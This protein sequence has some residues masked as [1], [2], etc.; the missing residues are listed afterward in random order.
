MLRAEFVHLQFD[1][2][3]TGQ[4]TIVE[5]QINEEVGVPHLYP[6]LL[7]HKGEVLTKFQ[8]EVP[9]I[10][11][12]TFTKILL[13]VW[14]FHIQ[15]LE[16]IG[17]PK[18]NQSSASGQQFFVLRIGQHG[19]FKEHTA[20][21]PIQFPLGVVVRRTKPKVKFPCFICLAAGQNQ[22]IICPRNFSHQW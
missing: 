5:K 11:D 7:T 17:I 1:C 16:Y 13:F 22:Q 21:L 20:D 10:C 8:N 9:Q 4:R 3:Q 14:F 12:D 2:H 18:G 15:K 6:I 19:S